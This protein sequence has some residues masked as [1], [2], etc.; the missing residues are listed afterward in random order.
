VSLAPAAA[1]PDPGPRRG[2]GRA[3]RGT[4]EGL[5]EGANARSQ[6]G[7]GSWEEAQAGKSRPYP[8]NGSSSRIQCGAVTGPPYLANFR[9]KGSAQPRAPALERCWPC[10]SRPWPASPNQT[11]D[12]QCGEWSSDWLSPKNVP[13]NVRASQKKTSY[14]RARLEACPARL[15]ASRSSRTSSLLLLCST[16]VAC[17]SFLSTCPSPVPPMHTCPFVDHPTLHNR[18]R[19]LHALHSTTARPIA[20]A[21]FHR[22]SH[23][24]LPV[25]LCPCCS[26]SHS[27]QS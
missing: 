6:E 7:S 1:I 20:T 11:V 12:R 9:Q 21:P 10:Y 24:A 8:G 4:V 27:L 25:F 19:A 16:P 13:R 22:P 15:I 26:P 18:S 5:Q 3:S 23:A 17:A 14:K 2:Q